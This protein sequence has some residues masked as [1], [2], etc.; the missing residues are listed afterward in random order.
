MYTSTR[1]TSFIQKF[2]IHSRNAKTCLDK[3][4]QMGEKYVICQYIN[5]R[6]VFEACI[7]ICSKKFAFVLKLFSCYDIVKTVYCVEMEMMII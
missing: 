7:R 2:E 1:W 5:I 3:L 6:Q 4:R